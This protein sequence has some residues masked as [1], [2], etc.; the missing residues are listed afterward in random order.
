[1]DIPNSGGGLQDSA[2]ASSTDASATSATTA[3]TTTT[4]TTNTITTMATTNQ[5]HQELTIITQT[6]KTF[7]HPYCN[8]YLTM[9]PNE[10]NPKDFVYVVPEPV[11]GKVRPPFVPPENKPHRNTNQLQY[12]L[13]T[14][15]K[16][17]VKHRHAWPFDSPVDTKTLELPDYFRVN[18]RPMDFTTIKKRLEN[19][20]YYDA[21]ECVVD[22]KQVFTNCYRYNR[23]AEDV[24]M[25]ARQ[26]EQLFL[27]K[28]DEMPLEEQVLEIPPKGKGKGKKG[29]NRRITGTGMGLTTGGASSLRTS[30][31]TSNAMLPNN[32]KLSI[33]NIDN[34]SNHSHIDSISPAF[35]NS[36]N[37]STFQHYNNQDIQSANHTNN[38]NNNINNN[39][40]TTSIYNSTSSKVASNLLDASNQSN[41][42]A[43]QTTQLNNHADIS[44]QSSSSNLPPHDRI[45]SPETAL[46]LGQTLI[47]TKS[48]Q[49]SSQ[50]DRKIL[51]PSNVSARRESGRPIKKPQ[52]DLPE[53]TANTVPSRPKK[54]RM[55]ERMKFCQTILKEL[56][57]K[58]NYE[59]AYY[60]Y[61]PVDA[62]AL[63]LK[64]YHDII[65]QPM[66]LSTIRK[67]M[68]A[69]EYR[70]PEQFE[71]DVRL[72]LRN[73]FKYNPADHDVNRCAR[74]LLE[75]FEQ[76]YAMLP[77]GSDDSASSDASNVPSS[78][79]E[80]DYG[81]D[82]ESESL[83]NIVKT[84]QNSSKKISDDLNKLTEQIR[85][86][87]A[88]I[89][90]GKKKNR[91]NVKIQGPKNPSTQPGSTGS[92]DYPHAGPA[93]G[94]G[95]GRPRVGSQR[96]PLP[97]KHP[98]PQKKFKPN[99]PGRQPSVPRPQISDS[100]DDENEVAMSYDE[101]RQL[102][103]DINK[104]RSKYPSCSG[105]LVNIEC[106][107]LMLVVIIILFELRTMVNVSNNKSTPFIIVF[108]LFPYRRQTW[109]SC[110]NHSTKRAITS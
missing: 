83:I 20:W 73:S 24:V 106:I 102:S 43:H 95:K 9:N 81:P 35:S 60:F 11:E 103:L 34:T 64:D 21:Y 6:D 38:N 29:G 84:L 78:A 98:Q 44:N 69:R 45:T 12:L 23:P 90:H 89:R 28:L 49:N 91:K 85:A 10:Y 59:V 105:R 63:G 32:N 51:R 16:A 27:D 26:V 77:E 72:M 33:L 56:L 52:K 48:S 96:R 62:E 3:V 58:K 68:E 30:S 104:L 82:S 55:T 40:Q 54:G 88:R 47:T 22:F 25:M 79:S 108:H 67:K 53:I 37:Q 71:A 99:R 109:Q 101:K 57:H 7:K 86:F 1:M 2:I 8:D 19:Y 87:S 18:P 13:K 100:E 70:K 97:T 46:G 66:D 39:A 76:K 65:K 107:C 42:I 41:N 31:Q 110:S 17:V 36:T 75:I 94:M 93:D 5:Q 50:S 80:S 92:I 61:D 74:K 15:H 4:T 14:I